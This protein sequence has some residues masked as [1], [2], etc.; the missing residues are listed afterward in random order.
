MAVMAAPPSG[1]ERSN[2][3]RYFS[4]DM[5]DKVFSKEM[6]EKNQSEAAVSD[7]PRMNNLL[8][9]FVSLSSWAAISRNL[10]G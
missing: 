1:K 2:P 9:G 7:W 8:C 10:V 4:A 5:R 3:S 6:S